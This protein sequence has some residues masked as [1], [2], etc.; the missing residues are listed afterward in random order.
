[1]PIN[2]LLI[3]LIEEDKDPNYPFHRNVANYRLNDCEPMRKDRFS[4]S[5][6][7]Q[8]N[9]IQA[10]C[11]S[12]V[13]R[14]CW[15][16]NKGWGD[17]TVSLVE[18]IN[19]R[20]SEKIIEFIRWQEKEGNKEKVLKFVLELLNSVGCVTQRWEIFGIIVSVKFDSSNYNSDDISSIQITVA[21][22][23]LNIINPF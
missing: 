3:E 7:E 1:M 17:L 12:S 8:F 10:F 9:N 15:D 11:V 2:R 19:P 4:F 22:I 6:P 5:F 14:P 20:T 21:P 23:E 13:Q 18:L 16:I